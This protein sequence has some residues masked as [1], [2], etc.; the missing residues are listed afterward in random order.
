MRLTR[1]ADPAPARW[2]NGGG[3]TRELATGPAPAGAVAPAFDWRLSLADIDRDGPFSALHGVDRWFAPVEGEV[4]LAL[5]GG[6]RRVRADDPPL[7]FPGEAAPDAVL[8][9]GLRCR[10]LNL[11]T[12]RA[13]CRAAMRRVVLADGEPLDAGWAATA[14]ATPG[15]AGALRRAC[16]VQRGCL[17]TG[18]IR[19]PAGVLV[20]FDEADP[21]PRAEGSTLLLETVVLLRDGPGAYPTESSDLDHR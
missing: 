20:E 14:S 3:V 2:A 6:M 11:M 21:I 7:S 1:A 9:A 17:V 13:R 10:A 5:P 12:A 19:V 16:F 4:L 15:A 8:P 18:T